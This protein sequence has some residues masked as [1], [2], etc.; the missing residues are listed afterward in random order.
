MTTV[1]TYVRSTESRAYILAL[2]NDMLKCEKTYIFLRIM[3]R[4]DCVDQA[5][6]GVK[7]F[8]GTII[9]QFI[10]TNSTLGAIDPYR[11]FGHRYGNLLVQEYNCSLRYYK[12]H[13]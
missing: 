13:K 2:L 9:H 6:H 7:T 8:D 1:T 11:S 3:Q 12:L 4:S 5:S 10:V